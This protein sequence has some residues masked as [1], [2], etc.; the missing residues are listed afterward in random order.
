MTQTRTSTTNQP[1]ERQMRAE[2]ITKY[3]QGKQWYTEYPL[4]RVVSPQAALTMT[5]AQIRALDVHKARA[6]LVVAFPDRL[7][8][9]EFQVIARPAKFG[10]LLMYIELVK[11]TDTL[12][13]YWSRRVDGIM[14]NA[15]DDPFLK[16]M[17]EKFGLRYEVYTPEWLD[18][19]FATLR[20]RDASPIGLVS[21]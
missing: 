12:S 4:G 5:A 10:S 18:A 14:I 11:E 21:A 2:Y 17:C 16:R 15:I 9:Y 8:I 19:Y 13:A 6:D 7:E 20:P 3:M 1:R